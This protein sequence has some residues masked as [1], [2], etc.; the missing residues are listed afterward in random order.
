M[1]RCSSLKCSTQLPCLAPEKKSREG[2]VFTPVCQPF[3]SLGVGCIPACNGTGCLPL[4]PGGVHPPRQTLP[5]RPL[6]RTVRILL[7]CIL[8]LNCFY[9]HVA[10]R[11]RIT[12]VSITIKTI[13]YSLICI[14]KYSSYTF[15]ILWYIF[16]EQD[17][18]KERYGYQCNIP[19]VSRSHFIALGR[20]NWGT[21]T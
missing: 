6:K 19:V 7:E 18:Y 8:V 16:T 5:V 20:G 4:S 2:N 13:M 17:R 11:L 9:Q 21:Y 1:S 3:C 12:P 14:S 15:S 10:L